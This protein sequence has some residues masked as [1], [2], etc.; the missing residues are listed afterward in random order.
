MVKKRANTCVYN[1]NYHL[2]WCPK[3]RRKI[4]NGRV[5]W[6]FKKAIYTKAKEMNVYVQ[7]ME[8]MPD[9][10][11]LYVRSKSNIAPNKIVKQF[12]GYSSFLIRQEIPSLRN[13]KC[14]WTRSY[15]CESVGHISENIIK[16]Y[17][18]NQRK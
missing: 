5:V 9:H 2:I 12:K 11:H 15:Y 17:I 3:Y 18:E 8:V 16:R 13:K 7:T 1:I 4:L 14:L 10:V 6:L